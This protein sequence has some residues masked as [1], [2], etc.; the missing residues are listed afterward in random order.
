MANNSDQDILLEEQVI[1]S[2]D[3]SSPSKGRKKGGRST[4]GGASAV[5]DHFLKVAEENKCKFFCCIY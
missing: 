5:W 1:R 4:G 3:G 2:A